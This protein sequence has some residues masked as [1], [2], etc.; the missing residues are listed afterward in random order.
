VALTSDAARVAGLGRILFWTSLATDFR[1]SARIMRTSI[2]RRRH[3]T[4]TWKFA[5]CSPILN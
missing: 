5:F 2:S 3:H 4:Y 1:G